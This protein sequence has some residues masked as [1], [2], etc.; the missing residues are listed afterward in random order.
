MFQIAAMMQQTI[1]PVL[2]CMAAN[3]CLAAS[4]Q[5]VREIAAEYLLAVDTDT[6]QVF[7][8][9]I[10]VGGAVEGCCRFLMDMQQV[11]LSL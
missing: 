3:V 8:Q 4:W 10:A 6:Y 9:G 7:R 11:Y 1:K 2:M 5:G